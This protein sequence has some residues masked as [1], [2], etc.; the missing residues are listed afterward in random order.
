MTAHSSIPEG[1]TVLIDS[2]PL[3]YT[4]EGSALSKPFEP[5]FKDIAQ[6]HIRAVISPITLAEVV[7]GPLAHGQRALAERYR[8]ALTQGGFSL[9]PIDD[10]IAFHAARLRARYKLKLPDAIQ[11]AVAIREHC[12]ALVTHDRDFRR[13]DE[14]LILGND[15][16]DGSR[17]LFRPTDL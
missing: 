9:V 12:F 7:S 11:L 10:E 15:A 17:L 2:N 1:A 6:G 5:I 4:F 13:V 3:I 16:A 8:R 14:V